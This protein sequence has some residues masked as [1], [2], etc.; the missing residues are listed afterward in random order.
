[1]TGQR[2]AR[3]QD[4]LIGLAALVSVLVYVLAARSLDATGFPLD[5]AWIHQTYA[6]NLGERGE[7]AFLPG[8]PS[9]ASTS[10]LYT[11]LLAAGYALGV[12]F[13]AW[14]FALGT[15]TLAA[16]GWTNARLAARLFPDVH[17]VG[18][19][20][21]LM[22][23]LA[24]HLV[25][26]SVSGM[27]TLLFALF[28]LVVITL[29]WRDHSETIAA[30][31]TGG[32][33]RRGALAG[34]AGAALT[35]TRPEGVALVGLAGAFGLAV[36]LGRRGGALAWGGAMAFGWLL[37]VAPY[38]V[39]NF[40]LTGHLLPATASAKQGEYAGTL[41]L[42]LVER[43]WM[44]LKPLAA[45]G[46]VVLLPG[47]VAAGY[48]LARRGDGRRTA[49]FWLPL[50]WAAAH[51]LLY[52]LRLPAP[53]QHGRYVQPVLPVVILYGVGGTLWLAQRSRRTLSGRV[54]ARTLALSTAAVTLGF[55]VI[56]AQAYARDVQIINTEM[57]ATARW[58]EQHLPADE[59]L[60]VHDIGALGYYAPR[61]IFD[62]AGLV[63]PEVVPVIRDHDALMDMM[64]ERGARYLMVLPDQRP[65]PADDPRLGGEPIFITGAPYAPLAGGGNMAVYALHWRGSCGAP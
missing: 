58:V 35:L 34:L 22:T 55:W 45:G 40:D 19:W 9:A 64:C 6:R 63:T 16:A 65:A 14:T 50:A 4:G 43:I 33:I 32:A 61:P 7:W 23:V 48:R 39:L 60:A 27:E 3:G 44:M 47:V 38:A 2:R 56:G 30:P 18:L 57:V 24:W 15:L 41:A 17:G 59:L 11:A 13:F 42:P 10:P 37:G 20:T 5:D 46:Q 36:R 21:G 49:I 28:A 8:E 54:L 1:M 12:P 31:G 62:L 52:A 26:A 29:V 25:W 51:V 53:Y